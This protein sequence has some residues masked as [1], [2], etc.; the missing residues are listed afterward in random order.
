MR[1]LAGPRRCNC[2]AWA[3]HRQCQ[4]GGYLG[5]RRSRHSP[6][7]PHFMWSR[8]LDRW[9][10]YVPDHPAHGVIAVASAIWFSGHVR[11]GDR[12]E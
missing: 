2:L 12:P 3:L 5:M 10:S 8:D 4:R 9:W 1:R 7:L 6:M 11:L